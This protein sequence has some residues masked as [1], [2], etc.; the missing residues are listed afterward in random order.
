MER[1]IG[2]L[3]EHYQGLLPLWLAPEQIRVIPVG[4]DHRKVAESLQQDLVKL[5]LRATTD[6]RRE[7]IPFK[8]RQ[9]ELDKINYLFII[10]EREINSDGKAFK[11]AV[12]YSGKDLGPQKIDEVIK[13]LQKEIEEKK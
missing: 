1:F 6:L 5:G 9:G 10:G 11:V 2:I 3:L 8:I 13:K 7:T 4:A 12:R